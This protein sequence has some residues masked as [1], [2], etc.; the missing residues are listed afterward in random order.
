MVLRKGGKGLMKNTKYN[1]HNYHGSYM[2]LLKFDYNPFGSSGGEDFWKDFYHLS[3][4]CLFQSYVQDTMNKL[5]FLY[6]VKVA[7][8]SLFLLAQRYPRRTSKM[9]PYRT[10]F[11]VNFRLPKQPKL[12]LDFHKKKTKTQILN[13]LT[14][15]APD[16]ISSQRR[17]F[18]VLTTTLPKMTTDN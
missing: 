1:Y 6:P 13:P 5:T 14:D 3:A 15:D 12:M 2:F 10:I 11:N 17:C 8:K 7:D 18:K 16:K 9:L 4:Q